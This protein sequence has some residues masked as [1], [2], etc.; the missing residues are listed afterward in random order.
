MT[1]YF[2]GKMPLGTLLGLDLRPPSTLFGSMHEAYSHGSLQY[3]RGLHQDSYRAPEKPPF[4]QP[5]NRSTSPE[6]TSAPKFSPSAA[7]CF[8]ASS[9][10]PQPTTSSSSSSTE[11][12]VNIVNWRTQYLEAAQI[13]LLRGFSGALHSLSDVMVSARSTFQQSKVSKLSGA[14][15]GSV[16]GAMRS[17]ADPPTP[18]PSSLYL[19]RGVSS[20]WGSATSP[21]SLP[22]YASTSG[23]SESGAASSGR[24]AEHIARYSK[25]LNDLT[26][27]SGECGFK[28][29]GGAC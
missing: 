10:C 11:E 21:L 26:G 7:S 28:Y 23:S 1:G 13:L 12:G 16:S 20:E 6:A 3:L 29:R 14:A 4:E 22:N 8:K 5:D 25:M 15:P 19:M 2:K 17:E 9:S 24:A 27:Y 18:P